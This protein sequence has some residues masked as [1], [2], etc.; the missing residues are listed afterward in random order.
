MGHSTM[1]HSL[2]G[3]TGADGESRPR[4][5]G[6]DRCDGCPAR[7]DDRVDY[8]DTGVGRE[9]QGK[10]VVVFDRAVGSVLPE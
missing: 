4:L 7:G 8:D 2:D 5:G 1:V 6:N 3:L 10:L 9:G